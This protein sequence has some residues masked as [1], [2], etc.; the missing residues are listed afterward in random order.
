MKAAPWA[1]MMSPEL[2]TALVPTVTSADFGLN[3]SQLQCVVETAQVVS[4]GR[5]GMVN[6][7]I[8]PISLPGR[9]NGRRA[10]DPSGL[11]INARPGLA[12][13]S[14]RRADNYHANAV[15]II[16]AARPKTGV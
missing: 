11:G 6:R 10:P 16:L 1:R 3:L 12:L 5:D 4:I 15:A 7:E 13:P 9:R 2:V 8:F 14:F